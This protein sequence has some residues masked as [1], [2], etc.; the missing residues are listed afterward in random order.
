MPKGL[1]GF[2]SQG[3]RTNVFPQVTAI[4]NI[5]KVMDKHVS[6]NFLSLFF[7]PFLPHFA[8]QKASKITK[9]EEG[10]GSPGLDNA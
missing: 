8:I 7:F 9:K 1:P 10:R 4:G 6:K 3:L 5:C 2:F